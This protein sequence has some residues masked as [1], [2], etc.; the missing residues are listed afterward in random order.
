MVLAVR[1]EVLPS[2]VL[3]GPVTVPSVVEFS[4]RNRES[5]RPRP[6]TQATNDVRVQGVQDV[7]NVAHVFFERQAETSRGKRT[8]T[9][10][11]QAW[12][13]GVW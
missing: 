10:A 9:S 2:L 1:H 7:V 13:P 12:N 3:M 4:G 6:Q 5:D 11:Q 8:R